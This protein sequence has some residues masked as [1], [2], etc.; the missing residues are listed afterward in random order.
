MPQ[1]AALRLQS[2]DANASFSVV[3]TIGYRWFMRTRL[4]RLSVLFLLCL[5][6]NPALAQRLKSMQIDESF[7]V[8]PFGPRNVVNGKQTYGTLA[9]HKVVN[10]NGKTF[11]CGG[12]Y[13]FPILS[14][15]WRKFI[16]RAAVIASDGTQIKKGLTRLSIDLSTNEQHAI[17]RTRTDLSKPLPEEARKKLARSYNVTADPRYFLGQT[18]KCVRSSKKWRPVFSDGRSFVT[19]PSRILVRVPD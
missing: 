11:I 6:V 14:T 13:N 15:H 16:Q 8:T 7:V 2:V 3:E 1:I 17:R 5:A 18:V 9:L 12:I 4:L 10:V 19:F